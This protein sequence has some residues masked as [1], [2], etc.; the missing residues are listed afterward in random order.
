[1]K[2]N[3]LVVISL[4]VIMLLNLILPLMKANAA[5]IQEI[6]LNDKLYNAV[7][8]YLTQKEGANIT[9][10]FND[11]D[12]TIKVDTSLIKRLDL[13]NAGISDLTGIDAFSSLEHLELSGNNLTKNSNLSVLNAFNNDNFTYLDLSSNQLED[14][15]EISGLIK[16]L[17]DGRDSGKEMTIIL[18]GQRVKIVETKSDLKSLENNDVS[19]NEET[20]KFK[21]PLILEKAGFLKDIWI[22]VEYRTQDNPNSIIRHSKLDGNPYLQVELP[23]RVKGEDDSAEIRISNGRNYLYDGIVKVTINIGDDYTEDESAT[24]L[25]YAKKNPL[26]DSKFELYYVIT[27]DR[28]EAIKIND[29]NLY[30]AI[31]EQ[32]TAGQ[33][34]NPNLITYKYDTDNE[35]NVISSNYQYNSVKIGDTTYHMLYNHVDDS[36]N[37][38]YEYAYNPISKSLYKYVNDTTLGNYLNVKIDSITMTSDDGTIKNGYRVETEKNLEEN[39][40]FTYDTVL[41]INGN[42]YHKL[43]KMSDIDKTPVYLYEVDT[44]R[45][46]EYLSDDE[47]GNEVN[48]IVEESNGT[49]RIRLGNLYDAA[50]DDAQ[51]FVIRDN[52]LVNKIKTLIINNEQISDL[53]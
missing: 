37:P 36:N 18:S 29:R 39:D 47:L 21:L 12:L 10:I 19:D 34:T 27:D 7:K 43:Y 24:N 4:I 25:N 51:A 20:T 42:R 32:L 49:Y 48:K 14:I 5:E 46:Y 13:N 41:T 50:Y 1:M 52:I 11:H 8:S 2:R 23:A 28:F 33:T 31:K 35:G 15:S 53:T 38:V 45:L 22:S 3:K 40:I 16:K 6:Q 30:D 9:A 26:V 44:G 17:E